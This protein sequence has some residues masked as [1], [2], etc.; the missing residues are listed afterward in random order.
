MQPLAEDRLI[1]DNITILLQEKHTAVSIREDTTE[2]KF[3]A[4]K[5]RVA[6]AGHPQV[7]RFLKEAELPLAP[8]IEYNRLLYGTIALGIGPRTERERMTQI[9]MALLCHQRQTSCDEVSCHPPTGDLL[10][11]RENKLSATSTCGLY[12]PQ[13]YCI[14]PHLRTRK[15][16]YVCSSIEAN[17]D[18][19]FQYH[20][21]N[22]IV[23]TEADKGFWWQAENGVENVSIRLDLEAEF[24]F[25][26][27]IITFRTFRP[28]AMII[29]RSDDNGANWKV[30]QYFAANCRET[31]P[32]V[33][34]GP[35]QRVGDVVCE[36]KYSDVNP[37]EGGEVIFSVLPQHIHIDNP[38]SNEVQNV[39]R[40]TNL[41]INFTKLHTLGDDLVD[42][43]EEV[44]RKY[45]YAI[46]NMVVRGSCSCYGHASRCISDGTQQVVPGMVYGKCDCNHNT[47]GSNC[48]RCK[49][50]Y[51]DLEWQPAIGREINA[52]KKCN[53]N[54]HATRCRFDRAVFD[55]SKGVSGGVCEDCQHNTEGKNCEFCKAFFYRDPSRA[56]D[57]PYVCQPCDCDPQ[58]S[59]DDGI[60]DHMDNAQSG[61]VAGKCHCK[62][63]VDGRRCDRCKPGYWNMDKFNPEGCQACA[64]NRLGTVGNQGCN[65]QTGECLCKRNV[66][67]KDCNQ[68][69][70]YH[71]G[72]GE[73]DEGCKPCD[74]ELGSS[75]SKTCNVTDGQCACRP[76]LTGRTCNIME[77]GFYVPYL[78]FNTY[79]AEYGRGGA[80]S[81]III[82][83]RRPN[84][85]VTWTG[86]GFIEIFDSS[87]LELDVHDIHK[88]MEYG[89]IFRFEPRY[90]QQRVE[91]QVIIDR[92]TP[93]NPYGPCKD[94][95][96]DRGTVTFNPGFRSTVVSAGPFCFEKGVDYKIRLETLPTPEPTTVLIDSI[97]LIPNVDG[98]DILSNPQAKREFEFYQCARLS[99]GPCD[100]ITGQ[101]P[102]YPNV[103]GLECDRCKVNHW[104]L[105]SGQGCE[106]CNCDPLGS[107]QQKCNEIDGTCHC[108]QGYGGKQCNEC[109]PNHWG[110]P[111]VKCHACN[112][113]TPGA[114]TTQ[115]ARNN[116]SCI[117]RIGIDGERCDRCAR[118]YTGQAPHCESCGECFESW[119]LIIENLRNQTFR[120]LEIANRIKKMGTTG[121]YKEQFAQIENQLAE[122]EAII[123]GA[124][125]TEADITRID[126]MILELRNDLNDLQEKINIYNNQQEETVRRTTDAEL[127]ISD[128]RQRVK[129]LESDTSELRRNATDL[130]ATVAEGA[131]KLIKAAQNRS[132]LAESKVRSS[133]PLINQ[134][135]LIRRQTEKLLEQAAGLYNQSYTDNQVAIG[136]IQRRISQLEADVPDINFLV[137]GGR[138]TV[139]ECDPLCGGALCDKC[140][141]LSCDM[142]ASTRAENALDFGTKA[143]DKLITIQDKV[144]QQWNNIYEAKAKA[145]EALRE[146]QLAY[147][148]AIFAKNESEDT[149][150]QIQELL[151]K[152]EMFLDKSN[153]RPAEIRHLAE[154]CTFLDISLTPAQILELARQ[155]NETI[156]NLTN[157]DKIIYETASDLE[158]ARRLKERADMAKLRAEN[159]LNIAKNVVEAL[160]KAL[161]AQKRAEEEINSASG[162]ISVAQ[163]DLDLISKETDSASKISQRAQESINDLEKRLSEL[164]YRYTQNELYVNRAVEQANMAGEMARDAENNA[165]EL[166]NKFENA[167][168]ILDNKAKASGLIKERA[169]RLRERARLLAENANS[170]LKLLQ[171]IEDDFD[172]NE[173]RLKMYQN[174]VDE[175]NREM[176]G[177]LNEIQR[178]AVYHRECNA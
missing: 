95:T 108:L 134:S 157:I 102:C 105:A 44:K 115:C 27:V 167:L 59:L 24:Q 23:N 40:I 174:E 72:L 145:D 46:S 144:R 166:E 13:R 88:S 21:I 125:V 94:N 4:L 121:A 165:R 126:T 33:P 133:L 75:Y 97:V 118:G 110:D 52:C 45:Y 70:P 99:A 159:I 39:I 77:P 156:A 147:Q 6:L 66:I 36:S 141:G 103:E 173:R 129:K 148:K 19:A 51:N 5:L 35:R 130:Q 41:R 3:R 9:W 17:R 107:Y 81:Q 42:N 176:T 67:G 90:N 14:L 22:K 10:I 60:C 57:D 101:C 132:R 49:D 86:T 15:K 151:D 12:K 91:A 84:Q 38:Y 119:D 37:S 152:I 122:I 18:D 177:H 25:T 16:C 117:C 78:D 85:E 63:N 175:L 143:E 92:R 64:C 62:A 47:T 111:R 48:E 123:K 87:T 142:G 8:G 69:A 149:T 56:I 43:R 112:C 140:G 153:A 65:Q 139:D 128:L 146:V 61:M 2:R 29:E 116:G 172:E 171:E 104:K 113:R 28:A 124:N 163:Q 154:Q 137:C 68:C 20:K 155:I 93:L 170:K 55:A 131:F 79:E 58:G 138:G 53:C 76:H 26:H 168:N 106:P 98:L 54:N 7:I 71:Y 82:R 127:S 135:E 161:E 114:A 1:K 50:L 83:E 169:E 120:L 162:H 32:H 150:V 109:E 164:K 11:G 89:I 100:P 30:Y 158:R 74:C 80:K 178:K 34:I 136:D 73:G 160:K 31:F 96:R